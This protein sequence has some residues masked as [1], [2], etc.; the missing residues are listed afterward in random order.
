MAEYPP[1]LAN[2]SARAYDA[3][4]A[5][6]RL[7]VE[8]SF[9]RLSQ[10]YPKSVPMFKRWSAQHAWV[11]RA[12][13][14]DHALATVAAEQ[15]QARYLADLEAHRKKASDAGQAL[16][17]V[18]GQLIKQLNHALNQPRYVTGADG[19]K[20][21]LHGVELTAGT[22]AIAARAMQTALDL[23]AHALGV[24]KLLPSLEGDDS[25]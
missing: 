23:E 3:F 22:F 8:R 20:Y 15:N 17:T 21:T 4:T 6:A 13:A 12:R 14:Y 10:T 16:Y 9:E 5:Y 19:K 11:E 25:E 2:E 18:A 1:Q 24:D 7:G